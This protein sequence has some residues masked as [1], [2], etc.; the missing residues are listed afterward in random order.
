M[1][2]PVDRSMPVR[3][4][5]ERGQTLIEYGMI[6]TLVSTALILALMVLGE[7]LTVFYDNVVEVLTGLV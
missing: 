7:D 6:L 5:D 2:T 4:A 1:N 3:L